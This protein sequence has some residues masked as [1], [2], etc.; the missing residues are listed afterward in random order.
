[1][2]VHELAALLNDIALQTPDYEVSVAF[3]WKDDTVISDVVSLCYN[4]ES[5]Q[6]NEETFEAHCNE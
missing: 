3:R 5:I 1:M 2:K 6:L 4:G